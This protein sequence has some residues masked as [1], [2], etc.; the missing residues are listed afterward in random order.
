MHPDPA[1]REWQPE[2]RFTA[3]SY[4][5]HRC[6]G[7]D[8]RQDPRR[9]AR[10]VR[11][12]DADIVGLQEVDAR[13]GTEDSGFRQMVRLALESG[14]NV[15]PGPTILREDGHFG[16]LLLT[17]RRVREIRRLD[18]SIPGRE[19]RGAIDADLDIGGGPVRVIVT[20]LGLR[21]GERRAQVRRLLDVLTEEPERLT[22]VMGDINEWLPGS[23][24]LR[25]LHGRLGRTPGPRTFPAFFPLLSLD[26]IWVWPRRAL[27]SVRAHD[28]PEARKASDHLPLLAEIAAV[29]M[30]AE[31]GLETAV[32][33]EYAGAPEGAGKQPAP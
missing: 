18:L 14:L 3:A 16:N 29:P 9:V 33:P 4:N 32:N 19:P 28:S 1:T 21:H 20:H 7:L 26:R 25:W 12:M 13:S 15:I 6:V 2:S 17:G 5:I 10:V 30:R 11:E 31:S 22:L 24:P 23:R 27:V 8:G